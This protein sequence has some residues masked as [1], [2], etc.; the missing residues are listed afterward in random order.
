MLPSL[1]DYFKEVASTTDGNKTHPRSSLAQLHIKRESEETP[2]TRSH[3]LRRSDMD[4]VAE[5]DDPDVYK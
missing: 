5:D 3:R 1:S 2:L 4:Q